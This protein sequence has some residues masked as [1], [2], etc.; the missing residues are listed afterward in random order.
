MNEY[1]TAHAPRTDQRSRKVPLATG[2]R[3]RVSQPPKESGAHTQ[4]NSRDERARTRAT[5]RHHHCTRFTISRSR[6]GIWP[7]VCG[8]VRPPTAP[9]TPRAPSAHGGD[10]RRLLVYLW[11]FTVRAPTTLDVLRGGGGAHI[12]R[13][14]LE[15]VFHSSICPFPVSLVICVHFVCLVHDRFMVVC[16][17]HC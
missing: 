17:S 4:A 2:S 10:P 11:A 16:E 13:T 3:G 1:V 7:A 9:P 8:A 6:H 5:R 15:F 14:E 12:F